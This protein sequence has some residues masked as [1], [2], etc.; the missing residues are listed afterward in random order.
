MNL[1]NIK[2]TRR[3]SKKMF[4]DA[5]TLGSIAWQVNALM[6][7]VIVESKLGNTIKCMKTLELIIPLSRILGNEKVT[8]FFRKVRIILCYDNN[9]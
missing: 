5:I 9:N 7:V 8:T 2:K 3:I 6:T 1:G 4:S